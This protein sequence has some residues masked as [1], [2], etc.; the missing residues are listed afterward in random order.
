MFQRILE[1]PN[2]DNMD[3]NSHTG[4]NRMTIFTRVIEFLDGSDGIVE[5]IPSCVH[6]LETETERE[7]QRLWLLQPNENVNRPDQAVVSIVGPA[8]TGKTTQNSFSCSFLVLQTS[9]SML[10]FTHE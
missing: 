3:R 2:M 9:Y 6:S 8:G 10:L 4:G 7:L 1:R 5:P